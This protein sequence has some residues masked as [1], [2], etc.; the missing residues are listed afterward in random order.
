M[1]SFFNYEKSS[2]FKYLNTLAKQTS[3]KVTKEHKD[4]LENVNRTD[5]QKSSDSLKGEAIKQPSWQ[6]RD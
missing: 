3:K 4:K 5:K 6:D 2:Q 1:R